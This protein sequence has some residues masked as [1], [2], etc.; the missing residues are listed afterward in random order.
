Y[1]WTYPHSKQ[2]TRKPKADFCQERN[3]LH[4]MFLAG[5]LM[6]SSETFSFM[7]TGATAM[8]IFGPIPI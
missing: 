1:F 8:H 6:V 2:F 7:L 4:L 3:L 5:K